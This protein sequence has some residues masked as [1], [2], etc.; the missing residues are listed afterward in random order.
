MLQKSLLSSSWLVDFCLY[1]LLQGLGV[2]QRTWRVSFA[3]SSKAKCQYQFGI[4]LEAI[5]V[6]LFATCVIFNAQFCVTGMAQHGGL[7]YCCGSPTHVEEFWISSWRG[8]AKYDIMFQCPPHHL[9]KLHPRNLTW[10]LKIMVSKWTFLFQGLI[11]RFHV[12]F[13]GCNIN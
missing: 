5:H 7:E 2:F 11:F 13:R 8:L 4:P 12:K 6:K 1:N 10:N 9:Y 3:G